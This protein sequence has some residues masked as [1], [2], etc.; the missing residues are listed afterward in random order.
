M[1]FEVHAGEMGPPESITEA[2]DVLGADRI[3]H[4]V[5]AI[6]DPL[7]LDRLV[8]EQVPLDVCPSSNISIGLF[9]S[10][11]PTPLRTYW[12]RGANMTISSD[13][14][15]FFGTTLTDELRNIV[16]VGG[17]TLDDLG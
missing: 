8:R 9:P 3:G 2:L 17:L 11:R 4:G 6:Y 12:E 10:W 5:A 14:P 13:D 15:P 16:R 7:L 1:G